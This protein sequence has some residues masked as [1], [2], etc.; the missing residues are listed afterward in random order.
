MAYVLLPFSLVLIK[1]Y[2]DF[3]V[4]WDSFTGAPS[5]TGVTTQKNG[6]G[7]LSVIGAFWAILSLTRR[8]RRNQLRTM[9]RQ[10]AAD[11]AILLLA[12]YLLRGAKGAYSA[13]AFSLLILGALLFF[14]L[15]RL[16]RCGSALRSRILWAVA[17]AAI[18]VGIAIPLAGG[19]GYL[20]PIL[21]A[22]GRDATLTGRTDIWALILPIAFKQPIIGQ[23]YGGFWIT[24][25]LPSPFNFLTHS[26]NGY[27]EVFLNAGLIALLLT[28]VWIVVLFQKAQSAL[29]FDQEWGA[30]GVAVI[31]MFLF[32]NIT[33]SSIA[34]PSSLLWTVVVLFAVVLPRMARHASLRR[35]T[36]RATGPGAHWRAARS[37]RSGKTQTEGAAK[38]SLGP[39]PAAQA[40]CDLGLVD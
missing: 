2:Q 20:S 28:M 32:H 21:S 10:C 16:S 12:L 1:Y 7:L 8:W 15:L 22:L 39:T 34:R 40:G 17:F 18:S 31:V 6:L 33:E 37:T 30:F 26:H 35:G 25:P 24:P 27:L 4:T 11:A 38:G 36:Q 13:T 23:G 3:G 14:W 29:R 19:A 9:R 5:W